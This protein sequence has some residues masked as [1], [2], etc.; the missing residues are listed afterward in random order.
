MSRTVPPWEL[1]QCASHC[2]EKQASPS[3]AGGT[4]GGA[5]AQL[6]HLHSILLGET[7]VTGILRAFQKTMVC[8]VGNKA[9][10]PTPV[11]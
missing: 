6:S 3:G 10:I 9:L 4:S 2:W 8:P 5:R 1:G 7:G 11:F